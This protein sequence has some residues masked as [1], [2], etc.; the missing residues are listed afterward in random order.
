MVTVDKDPRR[1]SDPNSCPND[2]PGPCPV[3]FADLQGWRIHSFFK[4]TIPV[5]WHLHGK[6]VLLM[7]RWNILC[8]SSCLLHLAFA[9]RNTEKSSLIFFA[10]SLQVFIHIDMM[11]PK[12]SYSTGW[13]VSTLILSLERCS[14]PLITIRLSLVHSLSLLSWCFQN[15]T[16]YSRSSLINT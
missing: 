3:A 11:Y 13:V 6:E 15:W 4:E 8:S 1:S 5:I 14:S 10:F 9:L 16:Q 12:A 7:F 2:C